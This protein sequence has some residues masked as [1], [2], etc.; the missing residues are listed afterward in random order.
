MIEIDPAIETT[1][2]NAATKKT[3]L[4]ER[5][6]NFLILEIIDYTCEA[7]VG[8]DNSRKFLIESKGTKGL[9][10]KASRGILLRVTLVATTKF[11]SIANFLI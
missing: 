1:A 4:C 5:P 8:Y 11:A 9:K 2:S 7:S 6:A 10:A 3:V